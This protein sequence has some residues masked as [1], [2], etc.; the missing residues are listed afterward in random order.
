MVTGNAS[1]TPIEEYLTEVSEVLTFAMGEEGLSRMI[2]DDM[3]DYFRVDAIQ[4]IRVATTVH[5][6]LYEMHHHIYDSL[7]CLIGVKALRRMVIESEQRSR[8]R[9]EFDAVNGAEV[10]LSIMSNH[11]EQETIQKLCMEFFSW[12]IHNR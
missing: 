10:V 6:V 3:R 2:V 11:M 7:V 5:A 4:R 1:S 9:Q 12:L 8:H